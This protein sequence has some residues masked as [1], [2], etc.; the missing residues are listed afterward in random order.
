MIVNSLQPT[1]F[2]HS[3]FRLSLWGSK[4]FWRPETFQL[5]QAPKTLPSLLSAPKT[6]LWPRCTS[7][8]PPS[9]SRSEEKRRRPFSMS[10]I[11]FCLEIFQ[12]ESLDPGTCA[13]LQAPPQTICWWRRRLCLQWFAARRRSLLCSGA[14]TKY[15]NI[16]CNCKIAIHTLLDMNEKA[17]R[18][19]WLNISKIG[20]DRTCRWKSTSSVHGWFLFYSCF[21]KLRLE[22]FMLWCAITSSHNS[23]SRSLLQYQWSLEQFMQQAN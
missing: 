7:A 5:L 10:K 15:C 9:A 13:R 6:L 22:L 18:T 3:I 19:N 1:D 21:H 16:A 11:Q 14:N 12:N 17:M 2:G 23:H 4:G 8:I 20:A